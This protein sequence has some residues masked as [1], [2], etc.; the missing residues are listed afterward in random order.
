MYG[1]D[2]NFLNDRKDRPVEAIVP[3]AKGRSAP[4]AAKLPLLIGVGV[5]IAG[6]AGVGGYWAILQSQQKGLMAQ[7]TDLDSRLAEL[8]QKLAQADTV[9]QQTVAID[10]EITALAGVFERI[11]PWSAIVR[12]VQGRT[13]S[14]TQISQL[15]QTAAAEE[16]A[17]A[18][19]ATAPA[20]PTTPTAAAPVSS[21][22]GGLELSGNAC[23]FDDV[24]DFM[25]T[26]KNS[27]FLEAE[28]VE[29]TKAD[30]GEIVPGRCP[31]DPD[32]GEPLALV[33]YTI[34]S[35]IKS[36]P[37]TE[38]LDELN[39]QQESTGLAA[40]IRALQETGAIQ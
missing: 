1:I 25:L 2:I 14:R 10:S 38:L 29:I 22:A 16:G 13:P 6:L 39:R 37:A 11:R 15:T 24:N 7:Q 32:T 18:A 8:Q 21:A 3:T 19:A 9:R 5:A 30:L 36:I 26:L 17:T 4:S 31:G 28:S 23:S 34:A 12:D 35:D 20:T 33:S 27:P 40:R